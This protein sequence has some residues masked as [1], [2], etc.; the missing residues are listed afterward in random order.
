MVQWSFL[1]LFHGY[2]VRFLTHAEAQTWVQAR[3]DERADPG[4][5]WPW[6]PTS[7]Y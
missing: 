6:Q 3:L 2:A 1:W 4:Q 7:Y 5:K